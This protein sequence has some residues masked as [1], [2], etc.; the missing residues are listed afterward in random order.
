MAASADVLRELGALGLSIEQ[1]A[2]VVEILERKDAAKK[3]AQR[4]RMR[5]V[6]ERA[7]TTTHNDAQTITCAHN[8]AQSPPKEIPHTPLEITPIPSLRS[9]ISSF[10]TRVGAPDAVCRIEFG[11]MFWQSYPHRV[12]RAAALRAF[13]AARQ[14]AS[15][16]DILDGL[17]R[18]IQQK[19]PDRQWLNP[20]RFLV[21]DRWTDEPASTQPSK[22][23]GRPE[24]AN[25]AILD[26]FVG[27]TAATP[28]RGGWEAGA[29]GRH[30]DRP[31]GPPSPSG[32]RLELASPA[33][34]RVG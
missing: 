11:T 5:A 31:E 19:P 9:G 28:E 26:A 24:P 12:G 3:A 23:T 18:Y 8:D 13:V 30:D 34:R 6:R 20:E 25:N 29:D 10:E 1:I 32:K 16:T 14:R 22:R 2:G 17:Q 21:D 4:E 7:R 27:L 15:L 33:Y